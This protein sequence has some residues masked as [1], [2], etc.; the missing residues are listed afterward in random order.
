MYVPAEPLTNP[1][2]L[3]QGD[4]LANAPRLKHGGAENLSELAGR[5]NFNWPVPESKVT[6]FSKA[7][8]VMQ[9]VERVDFAIVISNSCDNAS[10]QIPILLA[11]V[12]PFV[13][14]LRDDTPARQWLVISHAATSTAAPKYFYLPSADELGIPRSEAQ[15]ELMYFV[16]P[17]LMEKFMQLSDTRRVCG[18]SRDAIIHLQWQIGLIFGRNPREDLSWPSREDLQLKLA[19]LAEEIAKPPKQVP[20][21]QR[22]EYIREKNE[23]E[24]ILAGSSPGSTG[25]PST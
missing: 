15:L 14:S 16:T 12:I 10:G 13:F 9:A 6:A 19:W 24:S 2:Q 4:I 18:L 23:I 11:P 3:N 1:R 21:E 7:L 5:K 20:L 17:S 8:R 22:A 25:A